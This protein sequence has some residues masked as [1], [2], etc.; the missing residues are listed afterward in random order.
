MTATENAS[1]AANGVFNEVN[2]A[3][4][5]LRANHRADIRGGVV[6]GAD[7]Q[8]LRFCHTAGGEL[9][10]YR[11]FDEEAFDGKTNLAAIRVATPDGGAGGDV[12]VG[13]RQD[14]HGV[15]A[16]KFQHRGN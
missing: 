13:I 9:I 14:D 6:A 12:E 3:L 1:A 5:V 15:F 7:A 11:L 4:D 10:A 8:L 2:H 16:A